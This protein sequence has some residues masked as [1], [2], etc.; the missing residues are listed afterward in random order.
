M[1]ETFEGETIDPTWTE[2]AERRLL[3]ELGKLS[4]S[5]FH[6]ES[7]RCRSS[8]CKIE[9]THASTEAYRRY[10]SKTW[11]PLSKHFWD[12]A[13]FVSKL[14][15]LDGGPFGETKGLAFIAREGHDLPS[16]RINQ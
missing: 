9:T 1:N 7:A 4:S 13:R 6:V 8:I 2:G 15:G 5:D 11:S 16:L 14:D 10:A 12:A 3:N